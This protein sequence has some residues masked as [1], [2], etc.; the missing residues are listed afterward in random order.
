MLHAYEL[1]MLSDSEREELEIHLLDCDHCYAR[2]MEM[3]QEMSLLRNDPDVRLTVADTLKE[4]PAE[5]P[6]DTEPKGRLPLWQRMMPT[7]VTAAALFVFLIIKPWRL[8]FHSTEEAIAA[9]NRMAIMYFGNLAQRDDPARLGE[10]AANLLITDLSESSYLTV[11]SGQRLYDILK[12]MGREGEKVIDRDIATEVARQAE[13]RWMILGYILQEEPK[14]VMTTQLVDVKTDQVVSSQQITGDEGEDIFAL[15]DRLTME[16]KSDLTLPVDALREE[17]RFIA[18]V[19]THSP[20]A[21]RQYLTGL[22]YLSQNYWAEAKAS[23][24]KR[25]RP[26]PWRITT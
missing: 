5:T 2:L 16:I 14:L 20:E 17:D 22:D 9:E 12:A 24:R 19:T 6:K 10:I 1:G 21:Y 23:F 15:V 13:S 4:D 26:S 7:L 18:D 25:I 8:E 3:K 11:I